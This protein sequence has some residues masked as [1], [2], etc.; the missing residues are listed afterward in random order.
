MERC[1]GIF[2]PGPVS[3]S[4]ESLHGGLIF[5]KS[6]QGMLAY[7]TLKSHWFRKTYLWV[8]WKPL[9]IQ[10]VVIVPS[11]FHPPRH[12]LFQSASQYPSLRMQDVVLEGRLVGAQE[13]E[14]SASSIILHC[15]KEHTQVASLGKG[16]VKIHGPVINRLIPLPALFLI[17][18]LDFSGLWSSCR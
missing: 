4:T 6:C 8:V 11:G 12:V 18:S 16:Q 17:S 3:P 9:D 2:L 1:F 10:V 15:A 13:N 5:G 7:L 14:T